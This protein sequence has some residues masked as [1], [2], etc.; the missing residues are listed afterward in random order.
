M[1]SASFSSN[2]PR[3]PGLI[4]DHGPDSNALRAALTARSMSALSP[5]ATRQMT[6]PLVGLIVS[7]VLPLADATHLPPMSI[8]WSATFGGAIFGFGAVAVAIGEVLRV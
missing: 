8:F 2:P 3:S 7:N 5:S 6:S 1:M 4:F